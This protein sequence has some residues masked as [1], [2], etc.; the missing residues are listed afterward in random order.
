MSFSE[1]CLRNAQK[2]PEDGFPIEPRYIALHPELRAAFYRFNMHTRFDKEALFLIEAQGGSLSNSASSDSSYAD[3]VLRLE[4]LMYKF[5]LPGSMH[6]IFLTTP[7]QRRVNDVIGLDLVADS[8][9]EHEAETVLMD[10]IVATNTL[11][12]AFGVH[13]RFYRS[14]HFT[15]IMKKKR[16]IKRFMPHF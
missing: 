15:E 9:E 6:K 13:N 11:M 4:I 5:L 3:I 16:G 14:S 12:K 8:L 2:R 7:M 1:M 10:A